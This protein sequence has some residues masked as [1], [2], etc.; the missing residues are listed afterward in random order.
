[1]DIEIH[2]PP[3]L[4][5]RL[6]RGSPPE[7]DEDQLDL[8]VEVYGDELA[9]RCLARWPDAHLSVHPQ[10]PARSTIDGLVNDD[11][12]FLETSTLDWFCS[13]LGTLSDE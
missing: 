7:L 1:M 2:I 11:L 10:S 8:A 4:Y 12:L 9:A 5:E 3:D 6:R 13:S